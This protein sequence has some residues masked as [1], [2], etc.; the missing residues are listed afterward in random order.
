M[1]PG[2]Y[3]AKAYSFEAAS[4]FTNEPRTGAYRGVG[5]A[6]ATYGLERMMDHL[7]REVGLAPAEIRKPQ[8][9]S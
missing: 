1:F 9:P 5:R 2:Q 8:L 4:V 6:E 7:A 3:G